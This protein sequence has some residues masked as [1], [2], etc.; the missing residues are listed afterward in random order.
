M[1]EIGMEVTIDVDGNKT[2]S[3]LVGWKLMEGKGF[4][5]M[6]PPIGKNSFLISRPGQ[7]AVI[8]LVSG[9]KAFSV[10]VVYVEPLK[11]TGL[12]MFSVREDINVSQLRTE[13]RFCCFTPVA[14]AD[15]ADN[16][17]IGT[18][19]IFDLSSGGLGFYARHQ[20]DLPLDNQILVTF[21]PGGMA[22]VKGRKMAVLRTKPS[23]NRFEYSGKF[24]AGGEMDAENE[25]TLSAYLKFCNTWAETPETK[26]V[27]I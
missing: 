8:R 15:A 7:T 2:N 17:P 10:G 16:R 26:A 19:M 5:L 18:G 11:N 23:D 13:N 20:L 14:V 4:F 9:A 1:F 6:E 25:K 12:L 27:R 22:V 24:V 3:R 21:H